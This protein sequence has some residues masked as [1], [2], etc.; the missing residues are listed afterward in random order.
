MRSAPQKVQG[1]DGFHEFSGYLLGQVSTRRDPDAPRW[2]EIEVWRVTDSET[3]VEYLTHLVGRS[4]VYHATGIKSCNTGVVA[5]ISEIEDDEYETAEPCNKCRPGDLN[6]LPAN[7][8]VSMEK[9]R[10][11]VHYCRGPQDAIDSLKV[12]PPGKP[13]DEGV[14][15]APAQRLINQVAPRDR[16]IR[17]AVAV[18]H[19]V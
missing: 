13:K 2:L 14:L 8:T 7:A 15:S 5:Q 10:H 16:G 6:E 1:A 18:V 11:T 4:V 17:D 12:S 19:R 9:D 3:G